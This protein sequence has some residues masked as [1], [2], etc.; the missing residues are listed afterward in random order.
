[1]NI[2]VMKGT[3]VGRLL[4]CSMFAF[5]SVWSLRAQNEVQS[6]MYW[7]VPTLYNPATVGIDTALHVTAFDRMQ[8]VGVENA[9]Q[10]FFVSADLPVKLFKRAHGVG[11]SVTHD[12]AGLFTTTYFD[13]DYAFR[14]KLW[15]G[16]L[17]GGVQLGMVNQGFDGSKIYIPDGDAWEPG[18]D[19][20]PSSNVSAMAFD[21]GVGAYYQ[22]GWWWGGVSA[23]HLT[24]PVIDLD[25]YAYSEVERTYYF[26]A[27]GNI[28]IKRTLFLVQPSLLVKTTFQATQVDVTLRATWNKRFWGGV[29]YRNGDAIVLM[30]GADIKSVRIGYAYDIGI[31]PLAKASDGSHE[32]LATYTLE[33]ELDK[34]RKHPSKS[35]RI[36]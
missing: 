28:P 23:L 17:Q 16:I 20:L 19:A 4:L 10:T 35:I 27:G 2:S 12:R 22:R 1:M 33:F 6:S 26:H 32:I 34:K 30:A 8:W 13:L 24:K 15:G 5:L 9:P 31:S 11:V 14:W 29:T 18:D 36:L 21:A 7:A 25:E 3:C